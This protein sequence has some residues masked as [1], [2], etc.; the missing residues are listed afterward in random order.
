MCLIW[1]GG[2]WAL[3]HLSP[4]YCKCT[5]T[6]LSLCA[7]QMRVAW[8]I[9]SNTEH[10]DLTHTYGMWTAFIHFCSLYRN[11]AR[12]F[13]DD[14]ALAWPVFFC[15]ITLRLFTGITLRLLTGICYSHSYLPRSSSK[16][17]GHI[18][19]PLSIAPYLKK[20]MRG[21]LCWLLLVFIVISSTATRSGAVLMYSL[22]NEVSYI[23]SS[24]TGSSTEGIRAALGTGV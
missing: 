13:I 18:L 15:S 5:C 24:Y 3:A 6:Y 21:Q 14:R 20:S 16:H 2:A 7:L 11:L 22:L 17:K 8:G 9:S 19:W 4:Q 10:V 23:L 12:L 1:V